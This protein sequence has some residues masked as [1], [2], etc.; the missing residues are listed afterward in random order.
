MT[1]GGAIRGVAVQGGHA[2]RGL[3]YAAPPVGELRWKAPQPA[4]P[5]AGVRDGS[6]FGPSG[7]QP[8]VPLTN[9]GGE[10]SEDS[11]Y[12]NV[13]TPGVTGKGRPVL[14]WFHG[15]GNVLGAGRDYDPAKLAAKGTVVVTVNYRL[16]ALGFLAHPALAEYPGGPS[17]NYGLMDQQ[18][19]LRWVQRNIDRFGGD[20]RNVTIAGQ[21][22]GGLSVLVHMT[23][24]GS[25]GLFH[26]AILQSGS[27]ALRQ[28]SH[29]AA[30]AFGQQFAGQLGVTEQTAEQLRRHP[31]RGPG[32][33]LPDRH[34]PRIR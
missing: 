3:P 15:G 2:F 23:S 13:N 5:W 32:K 21:S 12:L 25:R 27:F 29:Q 16:G 4:V 22:S 9:V 6:Q 34:H 24:P 18:A 7:P 17:G 1:E 30:E 26:K 31:R 28:Q 11:L 14:V 10:L 19:A 33:Q 20:H 8:R